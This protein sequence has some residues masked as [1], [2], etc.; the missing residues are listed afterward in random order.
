MCEITTNKECENISISVIG[1]SHCRVFSNTNTFTPFFLGPGSTFNLIQNHKGIKEKL[2]Y[3]LNEIKDE[4]DFNM[5]IFGEP[6]CRYQINEDHHIHKKDFGNYNIVNKSYLKLITEKYKDII[7]TYKDYNLIVCAPITVYEQSMK[8]S[9]L[10]SNEIKKIC[11]ENDVHFIDI[12]QHIVKDGKVYS[13]YKS[14]PIHSSQLVLK[15]VES[16]LGKINIKTPITIY[17]NE[18]FEEIRGKYIYNKK[19]KCYVY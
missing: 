4:F 11:Q 17:E 8:F 18:R 16:E 6:S 5:L 10:F 9:M 15:Y 3:L 19:F 12:K 7:L 13:K 1:D 14:D 2:D